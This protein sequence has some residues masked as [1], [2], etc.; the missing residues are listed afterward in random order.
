MEFTKNG[1]IRFP[2]KAAFFESLGYLASDNRLTKLDVELPQSSQ[3]TFE[4][5]YNSLTGINPKPDNVNYYV[6]HSGADKWGIELRIY[7]ISTG[8]LP[9]PLRQRVVKSRPGGIHNSRI[10]DNKFIWDLIKCGFRLSDRQ[11]INRIE[12]NV[13]VTYKDDFKKGLLA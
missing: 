2:V 9:S 6:L 5:D 10:N 11:D 7:F 1:N 8:N 13:P 3:T 4:T 12:S